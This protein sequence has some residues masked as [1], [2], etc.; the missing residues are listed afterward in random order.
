[1]QRA[2]QRLGKNR[3]AYFGEV[4]EIKR[5]LD[6]VEHAATAHGWNVERVLEA[7]G[8]RI[9]GLSRAAT[10]PTKRVYLSAGIHGDEPAGPLA[11]AKMLQDDLWPEGVSLWICPCLNPQAFEFNRRENA[12]GLD[13]NRQYRNSAA[14]EIAAHIAWLER[15]PEFDLCL[16]LHE[17]WESH[18]FYLY[19]LNPEGRESL[20]EIMVEQASRVCPV[21]LA[22][23]IEGRVAKNGVIRPVAN[24]QERP[25]WPEAFYLLTHKTRLSYTLEAPSDY[26][27][28]TRVAALVAAVQAALGQV[29]QAKSRPG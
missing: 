16:C 5:V 6:E 2:A 28:E 13:L 25:D 10:V 19:E 17:D 21:D 9:L 20:A 18:G 22:P 8:Y 12:A 11:L 1:M 14:K 24:L 7:E 23:E 27:L 4:I 3:G 29:S 15:Q 26:A